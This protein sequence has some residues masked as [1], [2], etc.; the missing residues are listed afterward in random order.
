MSEVVFQPIGRRIDAAPGATLLE[1]AQN[2]GVALSAVCGG[3]GVCGDCRVRVLR[4]A[5]SDLNDT[6]RERLSES[7]IAGSLRLACQVEITGEGEIVV[8]VPPDSLSAAQRSQVEGEEIPLAVEPSI[9]VHDLIAVPPSVD[10]LRG[11]WERVQGGTPGIMPADWQISAPVVAG[12]PGVLRQHDWRTRMI[13]RGRDVVRFLPPDGVPLGFA[14][15]VGT[16]GLAAYLVDL[17]TGK[18]LGIAGA[19]NPQIAYGEDVMARL[20]LV[21]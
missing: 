20:T 17:I 16:T 8:D 9:R 5:V 6:E 18:T 21:V 3:M 2:A 15:D 14:V 13:T 19:T 7:D 1:A 11:D 4:G 10:D 12:L